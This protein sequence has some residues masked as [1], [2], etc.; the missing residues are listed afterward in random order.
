MLDSIK[1]PKYKFQI[2]RKILTSYFCSI[3]NL[4]FLI[5]YIKTVIGQNKISSI[6]TLHVNVLTQFL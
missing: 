4:F 6:L 2:D 1:Y 3:L 5:L